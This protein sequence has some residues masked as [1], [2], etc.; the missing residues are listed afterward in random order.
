[1]KDYW[2]YI[3]RCGDG[4]Y[5]T[6]VTS[7]VTRRVAKH[8]AGINDCYTFTRRPVVLMYTARFPT[9][10][11][12]ISF[13]KQLQGWSRAKK[14][15]LMRGDWIALRNLSRSQKRASTSSA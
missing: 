11:E 10:R 7:D 8:T 6:G 15:A 14:E 2:V 3:L 5:Y 9:P 1:V 12:A 13:E 4:T